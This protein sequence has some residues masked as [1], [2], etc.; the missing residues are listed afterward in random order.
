MGAGS[1]GFMLFYAPPDKQKQIKDALPGY[2]HVPFKFESEGSTIIY[3]SRRDQV[4]YE[5]PRQQQA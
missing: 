4:K 5:N 1:S 3:Y 2:L